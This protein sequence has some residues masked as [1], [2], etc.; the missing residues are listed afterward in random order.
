MIPL[1]SPERPSAFAQSILDRP[2]S[3]VHALDLSVDPYLPEII[4]AFP[5][6]SESLEPDPDLLTPVSVKILSTETDSS[7]FFSGRNLLLECMHKQICS[8]DEC[9]DDESSTS[10]Q[11]LSKEPLPYND[12]A[13]TT[14][15]DIEEVLS[16]VTSKQVLQTYKTIDRAQSDDVIAR[17]SIAVSKDADMDFPFRKRSLSIQPLCVDEEKAS[18]P[19]KNRVSI[20]ARRSWGK[21]KIFQTNRRKSGRVLYEK[22]TNSG[23]LGAENDSFSSFGKKESMRFPNI[24]GLSR[25][26]HN[27][28]G[29]IKSRQAKPNKYRF[30]SLFERVA[31]RSPRLLSGICKMFVQELPIPAN[32]AKFKFRSVLERSYNATV[33][34]KDN[35][36]NARLVLNLEHEGNLVN[37]ALV[38]ENREITSCVYIRRLHNERSRPPMDGF[39][40][41][42]DELCSKVLGIR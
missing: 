27:E 30:S 23:F 26:L 15:G 8:T 3:F 42:C 4:G 18:I 38:I 10:E 6:Q 36:I 40:R 35:T 34:E 20:A 37:V 5:L 16:P 13:L 2:T 7:K 11:S 24:F 33:E 14:R 25:K 17:H 31:N 12:S 29:S 19:D 41:F 22:T 32:V 28:Q 9:W 21:S 39:E 1:N